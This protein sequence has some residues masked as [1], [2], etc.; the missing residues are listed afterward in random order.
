MHYYNKN[1]NLKNTIKPNREPLREAIHTPTPH[2]S[3]G[4]R[5]SDADALRQ[6]NLARRE[7]NT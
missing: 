7:Q 1:N 6:E 2:P 5:P 3:D 4:L